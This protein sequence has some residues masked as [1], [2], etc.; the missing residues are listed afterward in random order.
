[1]TAEGRRVV[2][3]NTA[4]TGRGEDARSVCGS[5]TVGEI[6]PYIAPGG[7]QQGAVVAQEAA[8][9]GEAVVGRLKAGIAALRS[10][11]ALAH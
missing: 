7:H 3:G 9:S 10:L 11:A 1:V 5:K 6:G 2:A 4:T 8:G